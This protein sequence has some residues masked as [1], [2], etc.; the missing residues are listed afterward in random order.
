MTLEKENVKQEVLN[1]P[2]GSRG[3]TRLHPNLVKAVIGALQVIFSEDKY[4][5]AV[6]RNLLKS[7]PKWGSG[8]R[9]FLAETVYDVVRWWRKLWAISGTEVSLKEIPLWNLL[10]IY[11]LISGYELPP[12]KE[13][14]AALKI[15]LDER[16]QEINTNRCLRESIPDW[17]DNVGEKE[18]G[19]KWEKEITYLNEQAEVIIRV[20]TLKASIKQLQAALQKE[21]IETAEIESHPDALQLDVR[22]NIFRTKSFQDGL[23]E[24]QDA[25]SQEVAYFL[26]VEPGMRV[27]DACA[28]GGGKTL[29]M[30]S[31]MQNKGKIIALDVHEWKLKELQKR[32]ARAGASLIETRHIE[33]VKVIK[34]LE[35]TADR[36]LLDVPCSGLGVIRR[37]P[38]IKWKLSSEAMDRIRVQ[39]HEIISSYSKMLKLGGKMVYATCSIL[40]SENEEIVNKFT[41]K[42]PGFKKLDEKKI[43]PSESG[44]DGFYM[45][46]LERTV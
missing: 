9:K 33:T 45:A 1:S 28:G 16:I 30:A 40:P 5:D 2:L 37:N 19:A 32:A 42:N 43:L 7:N 38:D 21:G 18:L 46:I 31:L 39:Q 10:G 15:P 35:K 29:H 22:R 13:F 12:W 8:D 6:V 17:L 36:L 23:F 20:N 11:F 41:S 4:A 44:F 24:V 34:R 3:A 27:I 14:E 25:S 26:D